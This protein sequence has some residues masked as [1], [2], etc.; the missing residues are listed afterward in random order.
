MSGAKVALQPREPAM[1]HV[2]QFSILLVVVGAAYEVPAENRYGRLPERLDDVAAAFIFK[3]VEGPQNARSISGLASSAARWAS[4]RR[5]A[6]RSP[7]TP[8]TISVAESL[9]AASHPLRF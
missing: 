4:A 9:F 1:R 3:A 5:S 6:P 7:A 2:L 8:L